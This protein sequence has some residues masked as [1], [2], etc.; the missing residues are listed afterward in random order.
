MQP[1]MNSQTTTQPAAQSIKQQC[2]LCNNPDMHSKL[3]LPNS[4]NGSIDTN[5]WLSIIYKNPCADCLDQHAAAVADYLQRKQVALPT[6]QK[7]EQCI[8]LCVQM[9]E[10]RHEPIT[11]ESQYKPL[12]NTSY[13]Y[14][15]YNPR[16]KE[17]G[18]VGVT[19]RPKRRLRR[20]ASKQ[21]L[22]IRSQRSL[23][24]QSI[25][26]DGLQPEMVILDTTT[27]DKIDRDSVE[28]SYIRTFDWLERQ[29]FNNPTVSLTNSRWY[30]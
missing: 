23:W 8:Q 3:Y 7:I 5:Y 18:Y 25:Q 2:Q 4:V 12:P 14:A 10:G 29:G 20:H 21:E 28:R 27:K 26:N 16:T 1:I 19:D 13:I 24:I 6:T 15:L 9:R 22:S 11:F 17:V 30:R